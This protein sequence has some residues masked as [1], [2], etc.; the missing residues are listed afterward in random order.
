MLKEHPATAVGEGNRLGPEQIEAG[1]LLA[2][3]EMLLRGVSAVVDFFY[4]HGRPTRPRRPPF[5]QRRGSAC[6]SCWL[7]A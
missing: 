2:Y 5:A 3:G 4:I 7:G 6:E 1:A